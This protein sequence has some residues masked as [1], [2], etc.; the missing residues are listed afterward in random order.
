M[1]DLSQNNLAGDSRWVLEPSTGWPWWSSK[2]TLMDMS[3][4]RHLLEICLP[5]LFSCQ[6]SAIQICVA[7]KLNGTIPS[8]ISST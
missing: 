3:Q 1:L 5:Q 7:N 4:I 2:W 6:L 8:S